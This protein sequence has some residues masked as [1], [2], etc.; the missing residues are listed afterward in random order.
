VRDLL[1]FLAKP[2]VVAT[3]PWAHR[4]VRCG[5]VTVGAGDAS[6]ANCALIAL[7]TFGAD[8]AGSSDSSVNYS[9]GSSNFPETNEFVEH[10]SLGTGHCPVHRKLVQVW[11]D[12]AKLLQSNV[13]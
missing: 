11:L 3:T 4:T 5:L 6:P 10:A 9:R 2:T 1:P 7:P 8:V 12:L 13:I